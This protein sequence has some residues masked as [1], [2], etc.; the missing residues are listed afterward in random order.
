MFYIKLGGRFLY[1]IICEVDCVLE[2]IYGWY[3]DGY[4]LYIYIRG[5]SL[6]VIRFYYYC[7]FLRF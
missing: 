5:N 4:L 2:C 1:N 7:G 6:F 3:R